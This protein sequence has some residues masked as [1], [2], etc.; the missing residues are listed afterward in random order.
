MLQL[1]KPQLGSAAESNVAGAEFLSAR[2][3]YSVI[4]GFIHRQ[5][6][7]IVFFFLL[8]LGVCGAYLLTAPARYTG[9]AVMIMDTHKIQPFQQQQTA[10]IV[11]TPIDS[12][13]VDTQLEILK[14]DT[15]ALAVVR[16][17]H[18]Y[19]EPEFSAPRPGLI[20]SIVGL[21]VNLFTAPFGKASDPPS[22]EQRTRTAVWMLQ[23]QMSVRRVAVSYA[24]EIEVQS[25]NAE[26]A[27]KI[28]N[29]VADA[30]VVDTLEA[31]YQTTRRAAVWLQDRLKELAEQSSNAERAV[32]EFKAKNNIIDT[33]GKLMNEQQLTELNTAL[34]QARAQTAEAL[35]RKQRIEKILSVDNVDP[36]ATA[37]ATVADTLHN[38]VITRLRQNYVDMAARLA[39]WEP[40]F[41]PDHL[42][43]VNVRNQMREIRR[44]ILDELSRIAQTYTSDYE[45]A[46]AREESVQKSLGDMIAQSNLTNEAQVTLRM[47]ESSA[48]TYRALH[49]NFLQR[50]ME[51]VQQQSFPV[52][53][54]RLISP[55]TSGWK[56]APKVTQVF[57]LAVIGGLF[58]GVVVGLFRELSDRV[59]RTTE[60]IEDLLQADCVALVPMTKGDNG[61]EPERKAR[62]KGLSSERTIQPDHGLIWAVA[63]SPFS[64]FTESIRAI[65]VAADL[66]KLIK[67]NKVI[68]ITS[69]LP[70]EGKSTVGAALAQ[71]IANSGAGKVVLL[72]CDL[73]NPSLTRILAP[74][75]KLGILD[76]MSEKASFDDVVWTD[77][78]TKLQFLPAVLPA[79]LAHS[80]EVLA[81]SAMRNFIDQ[82]RQSFDYIIVDLSPLAP[83]VDVRATTQLVDSFL[84]VVEWGRTKIDVVEHALMVAR[85]V[86][87]HLLG[88]VLNKVDMSAL[89]RYESYRGNYYYNRYYARYGYTE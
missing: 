36:G 40:R 26:R 74:H 20:G 11:D 88:V 80:S 34:V 81:S 70:N 77:P 28:A 45:I 78:I 89:G 30:Y 86:H 35:A 65:K 23:S 66:K 61:S 79:R 2:A 33:G 57:L 73:R 51:S 18:L 24:I 3:L 6:S 25:L 68:G 62:P 72:D 46:K 9:H 44:A 32:V 8:A 29:A 50:Y 39:N 87:D 27:A 14:S 82:L 63:D 67:E 19:D 42:A 41:G 15:L 64:R 48:Q 84:F 58:M 37:T 38:E 10:P 75:A 59:F 60:Q 47:L 22:E 31:K 43:V 16:D 55:A 12:A 76:V 56:S 85:G 53:E 21:A 1:N 49:D 4:E 5:F 71:L 13:T 17:L 52:S 54:A 7:I 69:S 83:V